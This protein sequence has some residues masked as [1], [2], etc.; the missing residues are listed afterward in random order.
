VQVYSIPMRMHLLGNG[1]FVTLLPG[2]V[3]RFLGNQMDFKA[4]PIELP[5]WRLPIA[6]VTLKNRELS[7]LAQKF[8][9]AVRTVAKPLAG[10]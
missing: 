3:L 6:I 9:E 10:T 2:S 1:E 7:P 8:I 4:L 5:K